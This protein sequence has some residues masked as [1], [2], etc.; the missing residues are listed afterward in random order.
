MTNTDYVTKP[1]ALALKDVGYDE[2]CHYIYRGES[3][4]I[5]YKIIAEK[6]L[7]R[8]E[9]HAAPGWITAAK[10]LYEYHRIKVDLKPYFERAY[11]FVPQG[12]GYVEI[13]NG[14]FETTFL[15]A[16]AMIKK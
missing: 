15:A 10:W 6:C 12:R 1:V 3:N 11:A 16:I 8:S 7:H 9:I 4:R 2:P 14:S 13:H 5:D